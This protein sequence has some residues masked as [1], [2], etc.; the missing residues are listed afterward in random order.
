MTAS[1][2]VISSSLIALP[3]DTNNYRSIITETRNK[4][5]DSSNFTLECGTDPVFVNT[6]QE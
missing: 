2:C 3:F 5:T 6:T 4:N 1:F